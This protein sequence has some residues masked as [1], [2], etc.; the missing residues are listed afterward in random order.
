MASDRLFCCLQVSQYLASLVGLA[1]KGSSLKLRVAKARISGLESLLEQEKATSIELRKEADQC[2]GSLDEARQKVAWSE[3]F[4]IS[5]ME[6]INRLQSRLSKVE[7][8]F[9]WVDS[10]VGRLQ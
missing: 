6:R 5:I 8:N 1:S 10:E 4:S 7:K 9:L 2:R 3:S